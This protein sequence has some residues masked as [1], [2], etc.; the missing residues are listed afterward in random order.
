MATAGA[1]RGGG[2]KRTVT[3]T[4]TWSC[5]RLTKPL[6]TN[7]IPQTHSTLRLPAERVKSEVDR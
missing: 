1:K 5:Q 7:A 6:S 3:L 4:T 2:E